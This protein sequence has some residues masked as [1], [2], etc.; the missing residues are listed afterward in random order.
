MAKEGLPYHDGFS[1][2][3]RTIATKP[4]VFHHKGVDLRAHVVDTTL[5]PT[6]SGDILV[7]DGQTVLSPEVATRIT[8]TI[9]ST[10]DL[11][12]K[13]RGVDCYAFGVMF[14][15][16][17]FPSVP[18]D[19]YDRRHI[20]YSMKSDELIPVVRDGIDD[21]LPPMELLRMGTPDSHERFWPDHVF[22]KLPPNENSEDLYVSKLTK[23]P[24]AIT[25]LEGLARFY[26]ASHVSVITSLTLATRASGEIV[27][28]YKRR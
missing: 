3:D 6:V 10:Y 2:V 20:I 19:Q 25:D 12:Q 14:A 7:G 16:G 18:R 23:G 5:D 8:D 21:H 9:T 4:Q 22:V 13:G 24:V 27:G 1:D 28:Q 17:E 26:H 15:G 11:E